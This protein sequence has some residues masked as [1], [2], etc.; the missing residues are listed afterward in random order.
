MI[1]YLLHQ[2]LHRQRS[3]L[4][5]SRRLRHNRRRLLHNRQRPHRQRL[6]RIGPQARRVYPVDCEWFV[7][8]FIIFNELKLETE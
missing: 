6:L 2:P 1:T 7:T 4:P 5:R 3:C 8:M